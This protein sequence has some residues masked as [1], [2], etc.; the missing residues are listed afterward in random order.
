MLR[1]EKAI[2]GEAEVVKS[3]GRLRRERIAKRAAKELT[4]GVSSSFLPPF[5]TQEL[6]PSDRQCYTN[7]GI[8]MPMLAPSFLEPGTV[9]HLQSENG[10]LGT[11][12]LSSSSSPR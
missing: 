3:A 1:E 2:E 9:I 8:G 4:E 5:Q 12:Q 7:L 11:P 10:L 6:I